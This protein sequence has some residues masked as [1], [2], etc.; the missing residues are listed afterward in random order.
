MTLRF[1]GRPRCKPRPVYSLWWSCCWCPCTRA[2]PGRRAS[3]AKLSG[4]RS[5]AIGQACDGTATQQITAGMIRL[6]RVGRH[7]AYPCVLQPALR[8]QW[9]RPLRRAIGLGRH[10]GVLAQAQ[11]G[12]RRGQAPLPPHQWQHGKGLNLDPQHR[13]LSRAL[14]VEAQPSVQF[15]PPAVQPAATDWLDCPHRG[16]RRQLWMR[17][18]LAWTRSTTTRRRGRR[19][20][21][22][23][24][25]L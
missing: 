5:A 4:S 10:H 1:C 21:R 8:C 23:L 2:N 24:P 18:C 25:P 7:R 22:R 17:C 11:E 19:R 15:Q 20:T 16:Q 6:A 14:Q 9:R 12:L 13:V 3:W